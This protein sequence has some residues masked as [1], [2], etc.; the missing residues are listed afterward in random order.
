VY[1]FYFLTAI[2][3]EVVI[4]R[5]RLFL[6]DGVNLIANSFYIAVT[7]L[8]YFMFKPVNKSISFL[9]ALCSLLGCAVAI[10]GLFHLTPYNISPLIFFGPFC[11]LLGYLI[12]RST[13]LP[14]FIGVL[15]VMAGVGWLIYLFPFASH[16]SNY[17][18]VLGI[19]AEGSLMI[20]LI[21]MGVNE[22]RW[23]QQAG[24]AGGRE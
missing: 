16:L 3:A 7:V 21:A 23:R 14:R 4:G 17:L 5:S 10:L 15:M 13:F 24:V 1:L 2:F 11:L 12:F 20:W 18:K 6:Y 8:F 9:A 19:I 22:Q